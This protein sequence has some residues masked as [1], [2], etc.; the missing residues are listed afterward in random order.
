MT[1]FI[2]QGI[3]R[4][5]LPKDSTIDY[6]LIFTR[7]QGQIVRAHLMLEILRWQVTDEGRRV[8]IECAGDVVSSMIIYLLRTYP[9]ALDAKEVEELYLILL[10]VS[11]AARPLTVS[12]LGNM[13]DSTRDAHALAERILKQY[14]GL[15]QLVF[16]DGLSTG[17]LDLPTT[18]LEDPFFCIPTSTFVGFVHPTI[19]DHFK[20]HVVRMGRSVCTQWDS[21]LNLE[22]EITLLTRCL[23]LMC[24]PRAPKTD[25]SVE[26]VPKYVETYWIDHLEKVHTMMNAPGDNFGQLAPRSDLLRL[27]YIALNDEE[28][29]SRWYERVPLSLFTR[30]HA[31]LIVSCISTWSMEVHALKW[32]PSRRG[33]STVSKGQPMF[34]YRLPRC[35]HGGW[36]LKTSGFLID[37]SAS[38]P[39]LR[40]SRIA[41][42]LGSSRL[43]RR[44]NAVQA[45]HL[46]NPLCM[47]QCK[48]RVGH[49]I[50]KLRSGTVALLQ[51]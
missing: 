48:L 51:L 8:A 37:P 35:M 38:L 49:H 45:T 17:P 26:L 30:E 5:T 36:R 13:M 29:L 50:M 7:A 19:A 46:G 40:H 16:D 42:F 41:T 39:K 10:Y 34:S 32:I 6:K 20:D 25:C 27:L 44:P 1:K 24:K 15:L 21:A 14:S 3:A 28:S 33:N 9:T 23:E 12:E 11:R 47:S 18:T 43:R 31:E 22:A 2:N 4:L